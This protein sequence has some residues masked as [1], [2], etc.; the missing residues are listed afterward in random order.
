M[1][2]NTFNS[3]NW[4]SKHIRRK[5]TFLFYFYMNVD[6]ICSVVTA[7]I[8][9]IQEP[10]TFSTRLSIKVTPNQIVGVLRKGSLS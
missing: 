8:F 7:M 9:K 10:R 2:T 5:F 4:L 1:R 3:I 6:V